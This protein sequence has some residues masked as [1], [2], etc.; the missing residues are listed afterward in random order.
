MTTRWIK[1]LRDV[2]VARGRMGMVAAAMAVSICAVVTM[3]TTYTVLRREVPRSYIGSNPASAQLAMAGGVP[4][5]L[6]TA[7]RRMPN[8]AAAELAGTVLA[9]ID[10]GAGEWLPLLL[11]V[12]PDVA[13]SRIN[14]VLPESGAWPLG[15]GG[16]LIERSAMA[17]TR[18]EVGRALTIDLPG[19]GRR[20]LLLAGTVHDP[21]VAPAWQEQVIYGYVSAATL[22]NLGRTTTLDVI[23]LV[24]RDG[25]TDAAAIERTVRVISAALASAGHPVLEARIP[26]PQ[27]HPHQS[28][29]NA[30]ITMLLVFSLLVLVLGAVL[31]GAVISAWLAQQSRQIAIMK[32][33]GAGTVQIAALYIGV[34]VMLGALAT[35]VGL[36]LGLGAGRQF[37]ALV[38]QLLNL[39]LV[40]VATPWWVATLALVLGIGA[41]VIAAALPIWLASRRSVRDT[42]DDNGARPRTSE[43]NRLV[44]MIA[45][46]RIPDP[47]ITLAIRN[48]FRRRGRLVL[49]A[50][51]LAGAGAMCIASL[52]LKAA[53]ERNV[54][55][56]RRD[57]LFDLEVRLQ[58]NAPT[59]SVSAAVAAVRGIT[60]VESWE[61]AHAARGSA[62]GLEIEGTYPDGSHGG[63][64]LRAA[65]PDTRL[66]AHQMAEGR[67]LQHG[68][69]ATAVINTMARRLSFRDLQMGDSVELLVNRKPITVRIV[70]VL[71]EPLTPATL[72]VTPAFF[73]TVSEV[74]GTTNT[75]RLQLADT[76]TE[77]RVVREVGAALERAGSPVKVVITEAR[78]AAAQGGHVY[79]LVY[80]LAFIAMVMAIV[81][82]I[83]LTSSLGVS[84]L[85]R[86]REFGVMRA[87]GCSTSMIVRTVV[88]EGIVI[89]SVSVV[90]A[91]ILSRVISASVGR[92][93]A[94]ISAQD[95]TLSLWPRG[96]AL[97]VAGLLVGTVLVSCI[98]AVRAARLTVRNALSYV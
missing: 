15:N 1:M 62:D 8:V 83:G 24:V 42:I 46:W 98:P 58:R 91:S 82:L 10:V 55:D 87:I 34:V 37:I 45:R 11:F 79:I 29:M 23:A 28:Q 88:A 89:A 21:G 22:T 73:A 50:S 12:R 44:R 9:R 20:S 61:A 92:V 25:A 94:S 96:V 75:L 66:I 68:D 7:V 32:A 56:A 77:S 30:V 35:A 39:R 72:L 52:D 14:T 6:L 13:A 60:H 95:L 17:L 38:A 54:A 86:T 84:V 97:W 27:R 19:V 53:W 90:I 71:A 40:S 76:A 85:E 67:W 70:G 51:L 2:S 74:P 57:R 63:F 36:P 49:T 5:S 93:L 80:A 31:T 59:A 48:T 78:F 16:V 43:A 18:S 64:T 47:A 3:L 33:I 69:M 65:P 4:D 41:P 26:P 81:G